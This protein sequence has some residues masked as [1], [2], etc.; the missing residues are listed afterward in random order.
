EITNVPADIRRFL[1]DLHL[2]ESNFLADQ[3][4]HVSG[5]IAEQIAKRQVLQRSIFIYPLHNT[6]PLLLSPVR[7]WR[8]LLRS[9]N[10]SVE[11]RVQ[12]TLG[13]AVRRVAACSVHRAI[14]E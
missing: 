1:R 12:G 5:K 6:P 9:G 14:D 11:L 4:A 3:V 2:C 13:S 10:V 8:R 7:R